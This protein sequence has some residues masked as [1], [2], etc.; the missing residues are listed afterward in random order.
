MFMKRLGVIG[1]F[2]ALLVGLAAR[3][4]DAAGQKHR[5]IILTDLLNEPD[6]SQTMVRLLMYANE[7]D[8]EGLIAVSSCHLYA[9][10]NPS[11]PVKNCVHP[12][13]IVSRIEAYGKGAAFKSG[14]LI[15]YR[16]EAELAEA[17]RRLGLPA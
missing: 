13:E 17:R 14:I 15:G 6:D 5:M 3:P 2:T 7:L 16:D 4:L 9:G 12:E 10:K 8:I 1:L 11:N